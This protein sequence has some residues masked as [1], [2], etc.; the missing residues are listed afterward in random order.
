M[1]KRQTSEGILI[2]HHTLIISLNTEFC[3]PIIYR[4]FTTTVFSLPAFYLIN[5]FMHISPL[6]RKIFS[7]STLLLFFAGVMLLV[8]LKSFIQSSYSFKKLIV[9]EGM[10]KEKKRLP[11][12]L[13]YASDEQYLLVKCW[14]QKQFVA[15]IDIDYMDS[16]V[17]V[18]DSVMVYT[19][20]PGGFFNHV[21]TSRYGNQVKDT[22]FD[23]EIY[24]MVRK[25][26]NT[27]IKDYDQHIRTLKKTFWIAPIG[28][29]V[30]LFFYFM[31]RSKT[32]RKMIVSRTSIDF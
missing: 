16:V 24:H 21:I 10:I 13:R 15:S 26:D 12:I 8:S 23:N 28:S 11:S 19:K 30:C 22:E 17:W 7:I 25:A 18:D 2:A 31:R 1:E 20:P 32:G 5:L 4:I 29:F 9:Y 14:D 6:I 3:L 27:I